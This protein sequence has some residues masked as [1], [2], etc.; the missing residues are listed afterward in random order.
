[1]GK[2]IDTGL[3]AQPNNSLIS[4]I[5]CLYAVIS[6]D[7]PIGSVELARKLNKGRTTVNRL[8]GTLKFMGFLTQDHRRKYIPGPGIHVLAAQSLHASRLLSAT[9][10]TI[11]TL[12]AAIAN[13]LVLALGVLYKDKVLYLLHKEPGQ[14]PIDAIHPTNLYNCQDSIIGSLLQH[15][16]SQQ[17]DEKSQN[18]GYLYLEKQNEYREHKI[19]FPIG[20]TPSAKEEV[21]TAPE[22]LARL[23]LIQK[24]IAGLAFADRSCTYSE[25]AMLKLFAPYAA[26]ICRL[27][28]ANVARRYQ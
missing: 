5:E 25:Q 18:L 22:S 6:A 21:L 10:R 24:P 17:A 19:C 1:M 13:D 4:G 9:V 2:K 12:P 28:S 26:S 7:Q 20:H 8:L 15:Y 11:R 14:Q 3:P 23:R 16:Q 27:L